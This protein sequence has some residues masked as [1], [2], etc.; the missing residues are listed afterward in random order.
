MNMGKGI[1][2]FSIDTKLVEGGLGRIKFWGMGLMEKDEEG[3][4]KL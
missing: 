3:W 2:M 4:G 1:G